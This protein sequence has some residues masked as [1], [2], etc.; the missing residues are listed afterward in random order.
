MDDKMKWILIIITLLFIG[1]Y[2]KMPVQGNTNIFI[3][4]SASV[5]ITRIIDGDS[6]EITAQGEKFKLRLLG[7]DCFEIK[8]NK[9]LTSQAMEM[10]INIDSALKLGMEG[11][12]LAQRILLNRNVV[13][14]RDNNGKNMDS[15]GNL[16]R[17]IYVNDEN[18]ADILINYNLVVQ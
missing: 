12:K 16:L 5:L 13:I 4:D 2:E 14:K 3:D 18:F 15:F 8:K 6:Y 10:N 11:K 7:A 1:C 17:F 9:K